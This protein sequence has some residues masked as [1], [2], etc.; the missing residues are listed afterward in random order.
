MTPQAEPSE[1]HDHK[2]LCHDLNYEVRD[3]VPII[4]QVGEHRE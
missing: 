3:G 1:Y 4:L 2:P